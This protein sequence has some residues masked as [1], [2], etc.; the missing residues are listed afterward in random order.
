MVLPGVGGVVGSV[1][2]GLAG[3]YVGDKVMLSSY[4]SLENRIHLAKELLI[5][6]S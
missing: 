5:D 2:G 4:Q 1:I 3:G 6:E